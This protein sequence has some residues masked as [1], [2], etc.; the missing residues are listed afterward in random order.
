MQIMQKMQRNAQL[1]ENIQMQRIKKIKKMQNNKIQEKCKCAKENAEKQCMKIRNRNA[2]TTNAK[3][4]QKLPEQYK[5]NARNITKMRK[6]NNNTHGTK[7]ATSNQHA[8]EMQRQCIKH[9]KNANINVKMQ[10]IQK[11]CRKCEKCKTMQ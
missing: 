6:C 3:I 5:A 9:T 10:I 7:H 1:Q 4:L 2:N 11:Q 8:K